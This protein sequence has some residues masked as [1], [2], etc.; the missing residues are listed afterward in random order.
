MIFKFF[1]R[2][3]KMLS[4]SLIALFSIWILFLALLPNLLPYSLGIVEQKIKQ[5]TNY[6]IHVGQA[7]FSWINPLI[8][9]NISIQGPEE[10]TQL[11]IESLSLQASLLN[12]LIDRKNF[13]TINIQGLNGVLAL[14]QEASSRILD[15]S[16]RASQSTFGEKAPILIL[17]TPFFG[18]LNIDRSS[19]VI[20]SFDHDP[21]SFRDVQFTSSIFKS[22]KPAI[23]HLSCETSQNNLSGSINL[24]LEMGGVNSE[25][26]VILTPLEQDLFFLSP[27]SYLK[28]DAEVSN[29]PSSGL[30]HL[31]NLYNPKY[32]KIFSNLAGGPLN[33][34]ANI[35]IAKGKSQV[36]FSALAHNLDLKFSGDILQNQIFLTEPSTCSLNMTPSLIENLAETFL[37]DSNLSIAAPA[38]V[39]FQID[40]LTLPLNFKNLSSLSCNSKISISPM[41]FTAGSF[42][43]NLEVGEV[44]AVVDTF[45]LNENLTFHLKA[46]GAEKSRPIHF[47]LDGHLSKSN[48]EKTDK[49]NA[50]QLK[51]QVFLKTK[52]I[53]S[54]YVTPFTENKRVQ[55]MLL[56]PTFS[57]DLQA[58]GSTDNA[59]INMKLQSSRLSFAKLSLQYYD[60][61]F[62]LENPSNIQLRVTP[63]LAQCALS[64]KFSILQPLH[65]SGTLNQLEAQFR[66]Q[67]LH[68][69][70][71]DLL[72]NSAAFDIFLSHYKPCRIK[73]CKAQFYGA[74]DKG[75][76]ATFTSDIKLPGELPFYTFNKEVLGIF[77]IKNPLAYLKGQRSYVTADLKASNWEASFEG[78]LDQQWNCNLLKQATFQAFPLELTHQ[79]K[80]IATA[81]RIKAT[82]A[83]ESLNLFDFDMS[84]QSFN[85]EI[86]IEKATITNQKTSQLFEDLNISFELSG[87]NDLLTLSSNCKDDSLQVLLNVHSILSNKDL[88]FKNA[89]YQVEANL[90]EISP[91]LL[92]LFSS[93]THNLEPIIGSRANLSLKGEFNKSFSGNLDYQI[94]SPLLESKGKL[95]LKDSLLT[96]SSPLQI[97]YTLLPDNYPSLCQLFN[98][99]AAL[100]PFLLQPMKTQI[101]ILTLNA[102]CTETTKIIPQSF[103]AKVFIDQF[104][105]KSGDI[106]ELKGT[107]KSSHID[108]SLHLNFSAKTHDSEGLEGLSTFN[109]E[110]IKPLQDKTGSNNSLLNGHINCSLQH[111]PSPLLHNLASIKAPFLTPFT[112]SLTPCLSATCSTTLE[113]GKGP[114]DFEL[115]SENVSSTFFLNFEDQN[116]TLA[117]DLK[118]QFDSQG[119]LTNALL[120]S[121]NPLFS[122]TVFNQK[123]ATVTLQKAAFKA[124]P[125][126]SKLQNIQLKSAVVQLEKLTIKPD[127]Y[128]KEL[129]NLLDLPIS[130]T[131]LQLWLTPTTFSVKKGC[132]ITHRTDFL[133]NENFH[134]AIWG[135]VDLSTK[136]GHYYLA[137]PQKTLQKVCGIEKLPSQ[138]AFQ[139]PLYGHLDALKSDWETAKTLL[140]DLKIHHK[141]NTSTDKNPQFS[142]EEDFKLL[143]KTQPAGQSPSPEHTFPWENPSVSNDTPLQE[144]END[145]NRILHEFLKNVRQ[146]VDSN[147]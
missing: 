126:S 83:P 113:E 10:Q 19:I 48:S 137:I 101:E 16:N 144:K 29:L 143:S 6:T 37:S 115:S 125:N 133:V 138:Y 43:E 62:H 142:L 47:R 139:I 54:R 68:I 12:L 33:C 59:E 50:C 111:F 140:K 80:Q 8:F 78:T 14:D 3:K 91:N 34:A 130:E 119:S 23:A 75:L 103:D 25:E 100:D 45:D 86:F 2:Y 85:G 41:K 146:S 134:F 122:E 67:K 81:P 90:K 123:S 15:P 27:G 65:L 52:D 131:A 20:Q 28:L 116:L 32:K 127:S 124:L 63:E 93:A 128:L 24:K 105:T 35:Y 66:D 107:M 39:L 21:I 18:K 30:D 141:K 5:K 88:N 73:K 57:L 136:T 104:I 87:K 110:L 4:R 108:E 120:K 145:Q 96:S 70:S 9:K 51:G 74:P 82:L 112:Q 147:L 97:D 44:E 106:L 46:L 117:E 17:K 1:K 135:E 79:G 99:K 76:S 49:S 40:R 31:F 11:K 71:I 95:T 7:K 64:S 129:L 61:S 22:D 109:A 92:L 89:T 121:I 132:L 94:S 114:V 26:K 98:R 102:L 36:K 13:K 84:R 58:A 72:L 38:K 42:L 118:A 55:E 77:S 53:P 56:G 60:N 69:P